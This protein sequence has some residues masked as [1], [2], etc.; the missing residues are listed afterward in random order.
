MF[1]QNLKRQG[2]DNMSYYWWQNEADTYRRRASLDKQLCC[3][4]RREIEAVNC[5]HPQGLKDPAGRWNS[6]I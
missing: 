1:L 2:E 6:R 4:E 5:G 3:I